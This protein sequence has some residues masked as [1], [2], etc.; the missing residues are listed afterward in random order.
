MNSLGTGRDIPGLS[1]CVVHEPGL[2][3]LMVVS[4]MAFRGEICRPHAPLC[5]QL[6]NMVPNPRVEGRV[7]FAK[8]SFTVL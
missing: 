5:Q 8:E 2:V 4:S 6:A 3:S 7:T 1:T